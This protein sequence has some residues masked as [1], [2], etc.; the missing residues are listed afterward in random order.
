MKTVRAAFVTLVNAPIFTGIARTMDIKGAL[1]EPYPY[2]QYASPE[3]A[4]A[5]S[6]FKAWRAV[7]AELEAAARTFE[8][9]AP[10]H[11]SGQS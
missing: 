3:E 7:G 1:N 9:T 11:G 2:E 4:A 8:S 6:M 10:A 5:G